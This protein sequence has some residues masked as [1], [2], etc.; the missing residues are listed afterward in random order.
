MA[1]NNWTNKGYFLSL[2]NFKFDLVRNT[3]EGN[4]NLLTT[5]RSNVYYYSITLSFDI[6]LLMIHRMKVKR[7]EGMNIFYSQTEILKLKPS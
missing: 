3:P 4:T 1:G 6:F 5:Y 2:F 7:L